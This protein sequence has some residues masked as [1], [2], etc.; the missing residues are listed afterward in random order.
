[1]STAARIGFDQIFA[2]FERMGGV[3]ARRIAESYWFDPTPEAR[4]KYI[5]FCVP[6]YLSG[7]SR[8]QFVQE[9]NREGRRCA[10]LNERGRM[11]FRAALG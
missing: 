10:S 9:G 8:T 4:A 1:V 6:L 5:E 3:E 7:L 2:A 11:D